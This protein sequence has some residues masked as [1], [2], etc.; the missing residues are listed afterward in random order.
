MESSGELNNSVIQKNKRSPQEIAASVLEVH[1]PNLTS[2]AP[3]KG[4]ELDEKYIESKGRIEKLLKDGVGDETLSLELNKIYDEGKRLGIYNPSESDNREQLLIEAQ[5]YFS[6]FGFSKEQSEKNAREKLSRYGFWA[7][8]KEWRQNHEKNINKEFNSFIENH[9]LDKKQELEKISELEKDFIRL[10]NL[11][12]AQELAHNFPGGNYLFHGTNVK[13]AIEILNS[14]N[15][16]NYKS[17]QDQEE[18]RFASE[19]GQKKFNKQNSGYEGISWSF[20]QIEALPGDRYHLVGFL[21]SPNEILKDNLQLSV[22]SRPAPHELI[23]INQEI[24][25]NKFYTFK[26]QEELLV[27][28]GIGENNSVLPNLIQL[29]SYKENKKSD[30]PNIFIDNSM[31]FD[32]AET[33]MSD[34]EVEQL[35]R[36]KYSIRDNGTTQFSPDLLQQTTKDIPVGAVWLQALIDSG[37]IK[38]IP[39]FEDVKTIRHTILKIEDYEIFFDELKKEKFYLE[40]M[41][42]VED[43]KVTSINIPISEL[44]L[45]LPNTDLKKW[46]KVVTR[47]PI[48]P[49]GILTYNHQ[50]VRL[51]NFAS[52]HRGDHDKLSEII[53]NAIPFSEGYIHFEK[54]ILG[55]KITDEKL[56]GH[57]H[58][59]IGEQYLTN[60]KS[61]IKKNNNLIII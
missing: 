56:A 22:P 32:F 48:K 10:E 14:G 18:E 26:T 13:Q 42:K 28:F 59:V 12:Q 49:K 40:D 60:R 44:Y 19:G 43:D 58:Q 5:N 27:N 21:A 31:L 38:N 3:L 57:R 33:E 11:D 35:L 16:A 30:K 34:Y 36:T 29:C 9:S 37:R 54:D 15:L 4:K 53:R 7:K 6:N 2:L 25:A 46:L 20:N 45:V 1:S 61:V 23:L 51:E 50:E 52:I 41:I 47:S 24:N 55:E 17:L 39:G 8:F